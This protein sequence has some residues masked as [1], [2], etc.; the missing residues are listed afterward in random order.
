MAKMTDCKIS[1]GS[2]RGGVYGSNK[3]AQMGAPKMGTMQ[4]PARLANTRKVSGGR[5]K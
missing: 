3:G 5:R 2:T 1:K 4:T